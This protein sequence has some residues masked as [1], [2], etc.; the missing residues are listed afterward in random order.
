MSC[1]FGTV[2][3][4]TS[5][6]GVL[7]IGDG[8]SINYGTSISSRSVVKVGD[9]TK[10]GP[11]CVIA[12]TELPLPLELPDADAPAPIEIG[13]NVWLGGRVTVMP[14]ARIGDGA[15]VS[16]GSVVTGDI[17]ANAVASGNPARV[18]RVSTAP[19]PSG[20]RLRTMTPTESTP[21][22]SPSTE[23]G[24]DVAAAAIG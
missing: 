7:E 2:Q 6:K 18:L 24:C 15:V 17:P 1:T 5:E 16:A 19:P 23:E 9:R 13:S 10:I 12:D 8:V 20:A 4:A 14:G 22:E 21:S 11:Y 3:L